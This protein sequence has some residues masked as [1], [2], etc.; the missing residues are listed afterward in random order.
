MIGV[1]GATGEVGGRLARRLM[2][3]GADQRLIVRDPSRAPDVAGA[4]VA[5]IGGYDDP[6]GMRAAFAGLDV[7]FLASAKEDENRLDLHYSAVDAAA[8]AGVGRVVYLSFLG[9][10]PDTTFTFGRDHFHTE[11]RIKTSGLDYTFSRD[12]L[13]A[14]YAPLFVGADD[15][16]RGPAGRGRFA[17]VTRDDVAG[18]VTEMLVGDGHAG[19]TYSLTGPRTYDFTELAALIS[20]LSGRSVSY[21]AE[22]LEEARES[23]RPTGAP[24]W[25]IEGWVTS[26]AVVAAGE[27]DIVSDDVR[28]LTGKGAADLA[29]FLRGYYAAGRRTP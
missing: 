16:I 10:A 25:E 17:P 21:H 11:E 18:A 15:V 4:E 27:L 7:L 23:R 9:A 5:V 3:V 2:A 6:A 14:D 12:S 24:A 8:E 29:D 26:Y 20:E 28:E 13:Y 1:T 19:A 22:T